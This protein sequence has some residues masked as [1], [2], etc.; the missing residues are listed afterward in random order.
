M[1]RPI[2]SFLV[3]TTALATTLTC[4]PS[5]AAGR[6][7]GPKVADRA[8]PLRLA[9]PT[10]LGLRLEAYRQFKQLNRQL[11]ARSHEAKPTRDA[12]WT[13]RVYGA[14][15]VAPAAVVATVAGPAALVHGW[16]WVATVMATIYAV[17]WPLEASVQR[18]DAIARLVADAIRQPEAWRS[19]ILLQRGAV[20]RPH[21]ETLVR[22]YAPHLVDGFLAAAR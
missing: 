17:Y 9:R 4:A 20:G 14:V 11:R 8:R 3:V 1:P 18:K 13:M 15:G 16:G 6:L 22:R 10:G 12:I 7:G 21:F 5:L 2:L 19:Q